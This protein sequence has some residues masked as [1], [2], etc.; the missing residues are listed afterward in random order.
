VNRPKRNVIYEHTSSPSPLWGGNVRAEKDPRENAMKHEIISTEHLLKTWMPFRDAL[1]FS[2]IRTERDYK[3]ASAVM[4]QMLDEVG[5][6]ETH[7]L[8]EVLDYLSNQ[9]EAYETDHVKIPDEPPRDVL[10]FLME[11][12]GLNQSDL[13]DCAPQS[14]ISEILNGRREISKDLAKALAKRFGV[15]V[16]VFV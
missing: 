13:A 7:P 16:R 6:D 11:Q 2:S 12:Q 9:V 8:A 5:E 3:R 1:G 4:D 10:R 14:R 15:S